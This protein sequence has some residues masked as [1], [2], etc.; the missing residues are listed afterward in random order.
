MF[1][2]KYLITKFDYDRLQNIIHAQRNRN[3]Q[4]IRKLENK[5]KKAKLIDPTEIKGTIITM[6]TKF[7]LKDLGN[8]LKKEYALVFPE[9]SDP[10]Q[11]RVSVLDKFGSEL[12]SH[13]QGDVIRW[14][15]GTE[16][17]YLVESIIYQPEA[18]GDYHL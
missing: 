17:Y 3:N 6:N 18:A 5:F 8:G 15:E 2:K 1:K 7:R 13:E 12:F 16:A 11:N 4:S 9:D 14:T 10:H